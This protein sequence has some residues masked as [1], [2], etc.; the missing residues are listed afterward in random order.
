MK[1]HVGTLFDV[2]QGN[3]GSTFEDGWSNKLIW[4]DSILILG[5]L[6]EKFA[7][8]VQLI[9]I[10]PPFATGADFSFTTQVGDGTIDLSKQDSILEEKAYRDRSRCRRRGRRARPGRAPGR[11]GVAG[12]AAAAHVRRVHRSERSRR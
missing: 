8:Q 9:Y 10:D 4:G 7:G 1:G 11:A 5:S 12:G 3:E 6:V 2:Y